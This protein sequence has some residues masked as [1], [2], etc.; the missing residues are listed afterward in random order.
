MVVGSSRSLETEGIVL[1][2]PSPR[3]VCIVPADMVDL[4][5]R[6]H[7]QEGVRPDRPQSRGENRLRC[8][9]RAEGW[10]Q[11][12]PDFASARAALALAPLDA[13][14]EQAAAVSGK[15]T[16]ADGVHL[17]IFGGLV[18]TAVV[19]YERKHPSEAG[20]TVV[21][22]EG[23]C[24]AHRDAWGSARPR[25]A[26]ARRCRAALGATRDLPGEPP[27][28]RTP[29]GVVMT[30]GGDPDTACRRPRGGRDERMR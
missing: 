7:D 6:T 16:R 20:R 29:G 26:D 12:D 17:S 1:D 4:G 27:A 19:A 21:S 23:P 15:W 13:C 9:A 10:R 8:G 3:A 11:A 18:G 22:R 30:H 24:A 25:G 14:A 28:L 5:A 2:S